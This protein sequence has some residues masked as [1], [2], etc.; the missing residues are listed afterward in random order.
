MAPE[1]FVH[2]ELAEVTEFGCRIC[3]EAATA[4]RSPELSMSDSTSR[5]E[6]TRRRINPAASW[7]LFRIAT[8]R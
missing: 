6:A 1:I 5:D 8:I 3:C 4:R 2:S 7:I